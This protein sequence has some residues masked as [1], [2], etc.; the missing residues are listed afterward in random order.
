VNAVR[1]LTGQPRCHSVYVF[2][3]KTVTLGL[4]HHH[5]SSPRKKIDG[6]YIRNELFGRMWH[7]LARYLDLPGMMRVDA[8]CCIY[9]PLTVRDE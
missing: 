6:T 9:F 7:R 1:V 8:C 4:N 5:P 2:A 3:C